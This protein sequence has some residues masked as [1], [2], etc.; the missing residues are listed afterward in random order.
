MSYQ[1]FFAICVIGVVVVSLTFTCRVKALTFGGVGFVV[2]YVFEMIGSAKNEWGYEDVDSILKVTG[3]PIEILFGYFTAAFF[4][5]VLIDN[6][7]D[8]T[9][10][11]R[12]EVVLNYAFLIAGIV[13]LAYTY[14]LGGMLLVVGWAF[15]GI[16]GLNISEDRSIPLGV[17][18][19][20]FVADWI[21]EGA[22]TAGT[23]Y[24]TGGWDPTIALVF[25]FIAMFVT[26]LLLNQDR[27]IGSIAPMKVSR[28]TS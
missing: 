28:G 23:E 5:I 8:L 16:F 21:V 10:K 19:C 1:A 7:P 20:A 15:M 24:Y 18:M 22:L 2:G 9:T 14:I 12:R 13:L 25:M 17:G 27:I 4:I 26:G 6:I 3:I 11:D